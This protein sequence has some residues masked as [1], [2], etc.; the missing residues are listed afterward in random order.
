ME[1]G[2]RYNVFWLVISEIILL[3]SPPK[4]REGHVL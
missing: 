2:F 3:V 4:I 1:A